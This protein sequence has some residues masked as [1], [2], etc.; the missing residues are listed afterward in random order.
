MSELGPDWSLNHN[1]IIIVLTALKETSSAWEKV[2]KQIERLQEAIQDLRQDRIGLFDMAFSSLNSG[3]LKQWADQTSS[4]SLL[5]ESTETGF[6][7]LVE[8]LNTSG[9]TVLAHQGKLL[10]QQVRTF[11]ESQQMAASVVISLLGTY[12]SLAVQYPS[13]NLE[14]HSVGDTG[15]EPGFIPVSDRNV[16]FSFY[17]SLLLV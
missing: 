8:F 3:Q 12:S 1:D 2:H 16:A 13:N 14:A 11:K 5:T 7:L 4:T 17:S 10:Y 9:Q 6:P 15:I